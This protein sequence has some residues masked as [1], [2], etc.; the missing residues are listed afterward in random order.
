[1]VTAFERQLAA[2]HPFHRVSSVHCR[3]PSS[4]FPSGELV[5][6]ILSL[7]A[8]R[9]SKALIEGMSSCALG[10]N[11]GFAYNLRNLITD[12]APPTI[13]FR[14]HQATLSVLDCAAW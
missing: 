4:N 7:Q 8:A 9:N 10:A 1:M 3:P 13:E 6:N 11:R 14:Q 2:I 12:G 5:E